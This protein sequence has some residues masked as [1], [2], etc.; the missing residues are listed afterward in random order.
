VTPAQAAVKPAPAQQSLL[1]AEKTAPTLSP[2]TAKVLLYGPPKIG[3]ST[4]TSGINPE[5]TLFVATEPGLDALS[6]FKVD[7][8]SWERFREIGAELANTKHDFKLIVVDTVDELQ[9]MCADHV[10]Q[11]LNAG[12]RTPKQGFVHAS[13]FDY[14]KGWSAVTEEFR[15][16]VA[17]LCSLGLGVMFVSHTKEST[18]KDRTGAELT[19]SAPNVGDKGSRQWLLGFV[20]FILFASTVPG[21]EGEVRVL[22]THPTELFEAGGRYT[23]PDPLVIDAGDKTGAAA[24]KFA[25]DVLRKAMTE[26]APAS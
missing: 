7:C 6:V 11:G 8:N 16:R 19:K 3:K 9:R 13:D 10:I 15:L 14:G 4:L 12:L 21:D 2:E 24:A 26:A 18:I 23:L 1:P 17:R 22:R 5:H 25:G 20:D